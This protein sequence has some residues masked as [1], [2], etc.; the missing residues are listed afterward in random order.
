MA[1]L[2]NGCF[3]NSPIFT[4]RVQSSTSTNGELSSYLKLPEGRWSR[5]VNKKKQH[6]LLFQTATLTLNGPQL[7]TSPSTR[8][9]SQYFIMRR[10]EN[11]KVQSCNEWMV[12]HLQNLGTPYVPSKTSVNMFLPGKI[13]SIFHRKYISTQ[14][15]RVF[16]PPVQ[17]GPNP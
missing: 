7:V 3:A 9:C 8:P 10:E 14:K 5:I 6:L 11:M 12:W 13:P 2:K 17:A 15:P 16:R 4:T 1:P